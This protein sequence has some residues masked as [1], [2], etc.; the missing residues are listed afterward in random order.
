[1]YAGDIFTYSVLSKNPEAFSGY[2][3]DFTSFGFISDQESLTLMN[4]VP[5]SFTG[6]YVAH[7]PEALVK[8]GNYYDVEGWIYIWWCIKTEPDYY[9]LQSSLG[10]L[11][12]LTEQ[13]ILAVE[14]NSGYFGFN[15]DSYYIYGYTN[16]TQELWTILQ[17]IRN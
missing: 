4:G 11:D 5:S 15:W 9:D 17:Q 12:E 7:I 8:Q 1:M 16:T 3:P 13:S 6:H 10:E 14:N 2:I